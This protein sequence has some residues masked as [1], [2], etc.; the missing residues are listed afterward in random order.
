LEEFEEHPASIYNHFRTSLGKMKNDVF[1]IGSN[2]TGEWG[3]IQ[4]ETFN[5]VDNVW[6]SKSFSG[7]T[8]CSFGK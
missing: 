4:I 5:I 1:A 2:D 3:F 8:K 6:K 7:D